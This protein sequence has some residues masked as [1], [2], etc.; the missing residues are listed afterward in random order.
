[1]KKRTLWSSK[2]SVSSKPLKRK[3]SKQEYYAGTESNLPQKSTKYSSHSPRLKENSVYFEYTTPNKGKKV[4]FG[5]TQELIPSRF[6]TKSY[7]TYGNFNQSFSESKRTPKEF[8]IQRYSR[9]K[10]NKAKLRPPLY[11]NL[12]Q[13]E[14]NSE[15]TN[16]FIG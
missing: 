7:A 14:K 4:K 15:T 5:Q 11:S 3:K 1:M 8:R 12:A 16:K 2:N 13:G 9:S 6:Q 10:G